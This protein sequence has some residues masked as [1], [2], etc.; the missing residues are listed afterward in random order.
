M[1]ASYDD[2]ELV[3]RNW[4]QVREES[5]RSWIAVWNIE[6]DGHPEI[7]KEIE[8]ELS[9][10]LTGIVRAVTQLPDEEFT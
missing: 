10:L 4:P 2:I 8:T 6:L 9:A 5:E 3:Y 7:N 1:N